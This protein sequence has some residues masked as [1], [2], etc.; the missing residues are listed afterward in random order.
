MLGE[1]IGYNDVMIMP[2]GSE[3]YN[4]VMMIP[5]EFVGYNDV[6]MMF[7]ESIGYNDIIMIPGESRR[8]S[9]LDVLTKVTHCISSGLLCWLTYWWVIVG[10]IMVW[11]L[12]HESFIVLWELQL[13]AVHLDLY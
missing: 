4:D 7:G 5:G 9:M 11:K 10:A 8:G 1:S 3:G 12:G 13:E 2:G 6:M